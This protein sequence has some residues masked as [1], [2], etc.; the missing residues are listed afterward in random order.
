M[1]LDLRLAL[2]VALAWAAV[3][4][5]V[6]LP[7]LLA[8]VAIALWAAALVIAAVAIR[9][10][11]R[12][13]LLLG[14]CLCLAAAAALVSI[15]AVKAP[16]RQ[17]AELL[18]AASAGRFVTI[19]A[20]TSHLLGRA[21]PPTPAQATS[22]RVGDRQLAVDLP[23][24]LFGATPQRAVGIGASIRISGTLSATDPGDDSAFLLF[25]DGPP[26]VV[27]DPPWFLNWA[28]EIRGRF[29][30]AATRLPGSGGQLLPGLAIGD[31]SA[32]SA[33]LDAA[34]KSTSLSHLTAVSG[35]NCAVVVA[36]IM[37]VGG[38]IGLARHWRIAASLAVL[39]GF[40]V[41]VT[42]EPSVLRAA[43]MATL[44][45][46]ATARG[47]P[48]RG[49]PTLALAVLVLLAVDPWLSRS[50]GFVLSVLATAGLL[51]LSG[52]IAGALGRWLPRWLAAALAIP[53]AAQ[54]ACQPV[55]ILLNPKIPTYG[56]VA[57]LLA[58]P[59]APIATVV[60]LVACVLLP[61]LPVIGNLLVQVAWLPAAWIAAIAEF[62]A[63]LPGNGIPW[64]P[65]LFGVLLA[66]AG[67]GLLLVVALR[68]GRIRLIA[69]VCLA[70]QV[71]G[72]LGVGGG[73][74][75]RGMLSRPADWQIAACDIGQGDAVLVRSQGL[76]ALIDT[77]PDPALLAS[78]LD[79][80][81]IQRIDLLV[82]TH[83]DLDHVGGASAVVGR[84]AHA[85][86]GPPSDIHDAGL[87][88][89]LRRGG[90]SVDQ[91]S[92]GLTGRLGELRWEV[93]W[94]K[95]HL[96]PVEPGNDA[97]VTVRFDGV[98]AC[99]TGCLSS[100]FLG[101]L[102][103]EPQALMMAANR[104]G[105]ADVVKVA[106]HGSADQDDRLYEKVAASVGVIGVGI[107]NRYGHPTDALLNILK[108][109]GTTALRTDHEGLILLSARRDGK[110]GVWTERPSPASDDGADHRG[111]DDSGA[112]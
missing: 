92:Q 96:G 86:I 104:L 33:S 36:L 54:L 110:V 32:V 99:L 50:Y 3:A 6:G 65:G 73:E 8:P 47:R 19:T 5:L 49:L 81:G 69:I 42:P 100:I 101:D 112:D 2:P 66:A 89:R 63:R 14:V 53:I 88:D 46:A 95:A 37:I 111:A 22:V 78:C 60:G 38:A 85:M 7:A 23:I 15:S 76:V 51:V 90:A 72:L 29:H 98:G 10:T 48:L 59:A 39:L 68:R 106:H 43:V 84:V 41:L 64:P 26:K 56:V 87:A 79:T 105:R 21:A 44:V 70:L 31:T 4:V 35:A 9:V 67:G 12:R 16:A 57:N 80:L 71:V 97:S 94:P 93:L 107:D 52:P 58:E 18:S 40:V 24:V 17:P 13:D 82:L 34:M 55:L 28:N 25:A 11:N 91:V 109:V 61:V 102:G 77:G 45:L 103:K 20:T 30:V 27:A 74:R 62:F 83:Y 75:I 108:S 1:S